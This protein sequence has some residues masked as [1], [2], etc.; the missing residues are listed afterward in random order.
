MRCMG[1]DQKCYG[2]G[3]LVGDAIASVFQSGREVARLCPDCF[4]HGARRSDLAHDFIVGEFGAVAALSWFHVTADGGVEVNR[5]E[6]SDAGAR[7]I[8]RFIAD[9]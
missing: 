5:V 9:L 7:G 2:C 4:A 3:V 6:R 1:G 8:A